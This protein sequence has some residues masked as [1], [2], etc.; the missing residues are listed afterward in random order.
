MV[1]IYEQ[2][3]INNYFSLILIYLLIN[4][5]MKKLSLLSLFIGLVGLVGMTTYMFSG[6]LHWYPVVGGWIA[7]LGAIG[8]S[9]YM[10]IND[11]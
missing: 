4:K 10:L 8:G 9:I 7:T 3:N 11:K 2:I 6:D 5:N 1:Q